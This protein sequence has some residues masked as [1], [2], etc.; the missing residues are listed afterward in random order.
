MT[1]TYTQVAATRRSGRSRTLRHSSRIASSSE[2]QPSPASVAGPGH[3]VQGDRS[4][5]GAA[6]GVPQGPAYVPRLRAQF[7]TGDQRQLFAQRRDAVPARAAHRLVGGDDQFPHAELG[8]QRPDRDDQRERRAVGAGDDAAWPDPYGVR[9]DLG[10]DQRNVRVQPERGG[11]VDDDRA[12]G[13]GDRRPLRGHLVGHQEQRHVDVV[14]DVLGEL[15]DLALLTAHDQL[16]AGRARR[17]DQLHLAP[18]IRVLREDLE[19]DAAD[20]PGRSDDRERRAARGHRP[21]PP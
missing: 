11:V 6:L 1:G 17:G 8:V 21:V 15:E 4:G 7:R 12:L 18:D 16:A 3:H 14:E 5:E 19:H 2:D 13:G 9:I 10:H 20:R